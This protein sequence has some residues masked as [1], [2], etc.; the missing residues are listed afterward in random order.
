MQILATYYKNI[1]PIKGK[2]VV[3]NIKQGAHLIKGGIGK[4]KSF[5]FFDSIMFWLYKY[6]NRK[7]LNTS[8]DTGDVSILFENFWNIYLIERN[9][10][11]SS[12]GTES[13]QSKL[14][15]INDN[16]D[17]VLES[18]NKVFPE[19]RNENKNFTW[20]LKVLNK[21]ELSFKNQNELQN[22]LND[23]LVDK[24]VFTNTNFLMQDSDNIFDMTAG[25][26]IAVLKNIFNL[27]NIDNAK[28]II[29]EV[30][31]NN[32]NKIKAKDEKNKDYTY[33]FNLKLKEF[34]E[35]VEA[36]KGI[37]KAEKEGSAMYSDLKSIFAI[38]ESINMNDF[39]FD[40]NSVDFFLNYKRTFE[41]SL[42]KYVLQKEMIAQ[43]KNDILEKEKLINE[44]TTLEEQTKGIINKLVENKEAIIKTVSEQNKDEIEK[45][46]KE[47]LETIKNVSSYDN[48]SIKNNLF[49]LEG[50]N[51]SSITSF[52]NLVEEI[53]KLQDTIKNNNF[54]IL[55]KENKVKEISF[56]KEKEERLIKDAD[57]LIKDSVAYNEMMNEAKS[58]GLEFKSLV[59]NLGVEEKNLS[60]QINSIMER[61]KDK[62]YKQGWSTANKIYME[63]VNFILNEK[64][65]QYLLKKWELDNL[66]K[67]ID[68]LKKQLDDIKKQIKENENTL[69]NETTFQCEKIGASCPFIKVIKKNT[70]ELLEKQLKTLKENEEKLTKEYT[71][72]SI[73]LETL[74]KDVEALIE[75]GK[76]V[77]NVIDKK[78]YFSENF[79]EKFLLVDLV[80]GL[81]KEKN[82]ILYSRFDIDKNY[83]VIN[84]KRRMYEDLLIT[85]RKYFQL[86]S[87]EL[88]L[89]FVKDVNEDYKTDSCKTFLSKAESLTEK[90]EKL[91][92]E[93]AKKNIAKELEEVNKSI[94]VVKEINEK[95]EKFLKAI[96]VDNILKKNETI[97]SLKN[98]V[99]VLDE[100]LS[101]YDEV[102]EELK[103]VDADILSKN[104][105]LNITTKDKEKQ[106]KF[107]Q[108]M[109]D[110]L[111]EFEMEY[112]NSFEKQQALKDDIDIITKIDFLVK[113]IQEILEQFNK[114]NCE[115]KK[116]VE[117]DKRYSNIYNILNKEIVLLVLDNYIPAIEEII[118]SM[119]S[120]VVDYT[121]KF[122]LVKTKSD[123][124]ELE[125]V[126][127]DDKGERPVKS[128]SGGQK[129]ILKI[130]W[131]L[132]ITR[133]LNINFLFMDETINNLDIDTISK[134][135]TI[136][137][138]YIKK[139]INQFYLVTHDTTIQNMNIWDSTITF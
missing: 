3:M 23:V 57:Y 33:K 20:L 87:V 74:K 75:E 22:N 117:D 26:R 89:A 80:N 112:N 78:E 135:S 10:K 6:Q 97:L 44:L 36:I 35:L 37:K 15:L 17:K 109:K 104:T 127:I 58:I 24:D 69:K 45:L 120:Q 111:V 8:C 55:E 71:T 62:D 13:I 1:W 130:V 84:H 128:L 54:S 116:F 48:D 51:F 11:K 100:K 101:K 52:D 49:L 32:T 77:K 64:K 123:K 46:K 29:K 70:L 19:I 124:V 99:K 134:V 81:E 41:E 59:D 102:I 25:D 98:E 122:K 42:Q 82:D 30:K 110:N 63:K 114:D 16:L 43:K 139:N 121:L 27:N 7:I 92:K 133:I 47:K 108:L 28:E 65:N 9:I 14:Y 2:S 60:N 107:L 38:T 126:A 125:I 103:K 72:S 79:Q 39:V 31:T 61:A 106:E 68:S 137:E 105:E 136:L 67:N 76:E 4:G 131:V 18:I 94:I 95:I 66:S 96:D 88:M 132:A 129:V 12:S 118:N 56:N 85:C 90:V 21:E 93:F 40:N 86:N 138:N 83:D 34:V 73:L 50:I 115:I 119:L 5:H 53:L 91:Q 113:N